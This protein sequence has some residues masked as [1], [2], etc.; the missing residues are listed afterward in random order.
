MECCIVLIFNFMNHLTWPWGAQT[1]GK[2]LFWVCLRGCCW[3]R[4]TFEKVDR[5]EQ[6]APPP[7][8]MDPLK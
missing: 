6:I 3:M 8:Q 7:M 2:T 5:T 4:L 1:Y